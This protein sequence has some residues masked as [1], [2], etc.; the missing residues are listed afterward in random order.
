MRDAGIS[1][2]NGFASFVFAKSKSGE[3]TR[4]AAQ[5]G[6][7]TR[8]QPIIDENRD[9]YACSGFSI[10]WMEKVVMTKPFVKVWIELI[11]P[12]FPKNT[13][14]QLYAGNGVVLRIDWKLRG[15]PN[16]PNKRSRLI[17]VI[18]PGEAIDDCTDFK[19]AGS[20]FKEIIQ[21]K[22]STFN[23]DH[24]TPKYSSPLIEQWFVS[25]LKV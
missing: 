5:L 15:D 17:R 3:R 4:R 10:I 2:R 7:Y 11:R 24:D 19:M 21:A 18:I 8:F 1:A 22:L 16:R 25:G 6:C 23:P 13:R 14:I 12:L 20:R 9:F